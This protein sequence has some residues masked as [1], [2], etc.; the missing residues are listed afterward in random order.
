MLSRIFL[1]LYYAVPA[2]VLIHF[3]IPEKKLETQPNY[4]RAAEQTLEEKGRIWCLY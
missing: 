2:Q 4:A 1:P 3:A